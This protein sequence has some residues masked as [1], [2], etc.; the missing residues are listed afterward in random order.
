MRM[1]NDIQPTVDIKSEKAF[2]PSFLFPIIEPRTDRTV[3]GFICKARKLNS[4]NGTNE[5]EVP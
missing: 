4:L 2:F 3:R 5:K 1:I